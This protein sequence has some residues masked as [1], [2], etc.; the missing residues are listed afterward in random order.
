MHERYSQNPDRQVLLP[1]AIRTWQAIIRPTALRLWQR[2]FNDSYAESV[3]A[4]MFTTFQLHPR[5][6]DVGLAHPP[7]LLR[8]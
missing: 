6:E 5:V 4:P 2:F 7:A 3:A 8:K 1:M